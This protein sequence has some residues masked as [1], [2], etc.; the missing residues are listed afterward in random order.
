MLERVDRRMA[1][2]CLIER[3]QVP[4]IQVDGP[5]REGERRMRERAQAIEEGDAQD[6]G[7]Q[8]AGQAEHDQERGDV[9]QQQVLDHVRIEQFLARRAEPRQ[10]RRDHDKAAVEARLAPAGDRAP[11]A[12]ERVGASRV[13][14]REQR[15]RTQLDRVG[16]DLGG[17]QGRVR[18]DPSDYASTG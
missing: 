1:Q 14:E 5:Q 10:R 8:R 2:R 3:G 9:A 4:D 11:R 17:G 13:E 7:E 16:E 18:H 6:R 15:Q 12:G